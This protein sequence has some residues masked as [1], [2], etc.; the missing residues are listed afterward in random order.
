MTER[1]LKY[2]PTFN[3]SLYTTSEKLQ[4]PH[5]LRCII[6]FRHSSRLKAIRKTRKRWSIMFHICGFI[7]NARI[8]WFWKIPTAVLRHSLPFFC[9]QNA[10]NSFA[11]NISPVNPVSVHG[12]Q[13]K[14]ANLNLFLP[15]TFDP[16][17]HAAAAVIYWEGWE[18]V[19]KPATTTIVMSGKRTY[20][21]ATE[22]LCNIGWWSNATT[23]R[24]LKMSVPWKFHFQKLYSFTL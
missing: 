4:Q 16:I 14:F 3:K 23:R 8:P 20:C 11:V 19:C 7:V 15:Q 24:L 9:K 5:F 10:W 1:A 2:F 18:Q 13:T 21:F 6:N 22:N 17:F 12:K